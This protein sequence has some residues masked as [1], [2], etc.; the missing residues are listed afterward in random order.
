MQQQ[1]INGTDF[2][3]FPSRETVEHSLFWMGDNYL[4]K[5]QNDFTEQLRAQDAGTTVIAIKSQTEPEFQHTVSSG[6]GTIH[7][8]TVT[9]QL[10]VLVK[11]GSGKHWRLNG[12]CVYAGTELHTENPELNMDFELKSA[13]PV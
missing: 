13:D 10:Q 11:D 2:H 8:V 3:N 5:I 7:A 4:L 9:F 12:T 6:N 1:Q